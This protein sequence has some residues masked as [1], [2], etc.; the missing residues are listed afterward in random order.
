M[1]KYYKSPMNYTG[2]KYKIIDQI[3]PFFP[4]EI[5]TFLDLFAGGCNVSANVLADKI[6]CND[7]NYHTIEL[8][9]SFLGVS[10][11][12]V[13]AHIDKRIEEFQLSKT[14]ET[15]Y[16]QFRRFY[17]ETKHAWDLYTLM[18][19]SFN[20][21]LRFNTNHDYNNPFGKNRSS[22]NPSMRENLISF[23]NVLNNKNIEFQSNDFN[24]IDFSSLKK[25][26][27]L[28]ADPPYLITCGS[29][30]DGKRG[31]KGWNDED[32]I[33]LL[34]ILDIINENNIKFALSNVLEHK[35]IK[36]DLL[37]EWSSK[38]HIH[39]INCNYDNCNYQK[40]APGKT[41]E[42]LITNY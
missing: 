16:S 30:N 28:Y 26:D 35:G 9:N 17:N 22:F 41:R 7:I 14:N 42:I 31:F 32:E 27:F 3:L 34:K 6:V 2:G 40:K 24:L 4:G 13:L 38:Y 5:N 10:P 20:Y 21:Q 37:I 11:D 12:V 29:Y 15:G 23:I 36:N 8:Y 1:K 18:S 25:G 19:F 39:E 33:M